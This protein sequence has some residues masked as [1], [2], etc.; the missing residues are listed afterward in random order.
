MSSWILK[1]SWRRQEK[2]S[3][4]RVVRRLGELALVVFVLRKRSSLNDFSVAAMI[5]TLNCDCHVSGR[6]GHLACMALSSW[7]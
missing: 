6:F 3:K 1:N 2:H 7:R 5:S 4:S